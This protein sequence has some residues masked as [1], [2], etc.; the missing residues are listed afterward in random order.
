MLISLA[1]AIITSGFGSF[2]SL[3]IISVTTSLCLSRLK[4]KGHRAFEK[5]VLAREPS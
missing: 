4:V 2:E 1:A 3:Y 5:A